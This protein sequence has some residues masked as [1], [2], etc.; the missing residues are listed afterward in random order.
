MSTANVKCWWPL[1]S[2]E[3]FI[4]ILTVILFLVNGPFSAEQHANGFEAGGLVVLKHAVSLLFGSEA[5]G[6]DYCWL[7]VKSREI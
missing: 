5:I 2:T 7:I 4:I 6:N 1:Y 3:N